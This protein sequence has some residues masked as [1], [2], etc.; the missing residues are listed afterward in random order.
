[1]MSRE[2]ESVQSCRSCD[3]HEVV[4]LITEHSRLLDSREVEALASLCD[5]ELDFQFRD[6]GAFHG[7]NA[8]KGLARLARVAVRH[9]HIVTNVRVDSHGANG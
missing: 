3:E 4:K 1:M 9:R 2:E 7:R 6:G 5:D 8:G